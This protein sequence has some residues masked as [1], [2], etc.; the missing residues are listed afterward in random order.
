MT[1][2]FY[3]P[4]PLAPATGG[5]RVFRSSRCRMFC[6]IFLPALPRARCE[7]LIA[8]EALA[9]CG[10]AD[11]EDLIGMKVRQCDPESGV[12]F[13]R[14]QVA[15]ASA[16]LY[17][18][19]SGTWTETGSLANGFQKEEQQSTCQEWQEPPRVTPYALSPTLSSA[20]VEEVGRRIG[21]PRLLPVP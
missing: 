7:A 6:R 13:P 15:L 1:C 10:G 14:E 16:E 12:T 9:I 4:G 11:K 20:W 2:R 3:F 8:E 18:P 19:A 17:D 21:R 5:S